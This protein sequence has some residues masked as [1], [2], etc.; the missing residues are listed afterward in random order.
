MNSVIYIYIYIYDQGKYGDI[1]SE[2]NDQGKYGDQAVLQ[3]L[4][5][6]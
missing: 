2:I 6:Q 3:N 1:S 4:Y 5:D